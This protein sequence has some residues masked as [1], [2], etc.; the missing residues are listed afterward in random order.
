MDII[1]LHV[2]NG[3]CPKAAEMSLPEILANIKR[4]GIMQ[5]MIFP[6]NEE[7]AGPSSLHSNMTI[8]ELCEQ[9]KAFIPCA[10]L[11]LNKLHATYDEIKTAKQ[12]SG[13]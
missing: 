1:D 3:R 6:I 4:S 11:N 9:H 8:A 7:N 10:R 2:R 13:V 12:F 5:S